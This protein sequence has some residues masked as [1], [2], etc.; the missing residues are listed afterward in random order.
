MRA[1]TIP[2][3]LAVALLASC[4]FLPAT[5]SDHGPPPSENY[6]AEIRERMGQSL[7]DPDSARYEIGQPRRREFRR[8]WFRTTFYGWGVPFTCNAK[9]SF[10]GYVGRQ[11]YIA[12]FR[13]G[14]L[15]LIG[16]SLGFPVGSVWGSAVSRWA[17]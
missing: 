11:S 3:A 16:D 17:R 2:A 14:R 8:G 13:D 6:R 9:N 1:K 5:G 10:G 7:K 15:V 12:V 4:A